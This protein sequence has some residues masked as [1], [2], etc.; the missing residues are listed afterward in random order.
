MSS[1]VLE[2]NEVDAGYAGANV[3]H[4]VSLEVRPGE[5]IALLGA[6]GAGKSTLLQVMA[7]ALR[8]SA[9]RLLVEGKDV[10]GLRTNR[11]AYLGVRW[12]GDPRPIYPEMTVDDN[13]IMGGF[14]NRR[15]IPQRKADIY[16]AFPELASRRESK[17]GA[18]SGGQAQIL[19]IAQSLMSNPRLLL[20]DEPSTGLSVAILQRLAEIVDGLGREGVAVIWAEQ[21]PDVAL[22]S[23]D[24]AIVVAAGHASGKVPSAQLDVSVIEDAYLG[25][26]M[27]PKI[28]ESGSHTVA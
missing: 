23:C 14:S 5:R 17:A 22:R 9:G 21:F 10:T 11:W 15:A 2:L 4:G 28:G 6:N 16:D 27:L 20:L 7:G 12:V 3:I 25:S 1:P 26:A 19:A 18:L 24:S 13:L 8:V